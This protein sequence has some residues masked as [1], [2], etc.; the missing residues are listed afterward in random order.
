MRR[1]EKMPAELGLSIADE[2][3]VMNVIHK[4]EKGCQRKPET[5]GDY[6]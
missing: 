6:K 5:K 2:L 4:V 3:T 1:T